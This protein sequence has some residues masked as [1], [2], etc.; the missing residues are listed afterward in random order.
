MLIVN[1]KTYN[2][3]VEEV[4][5]ALKPEIVNGKLSR[6]KVTSSGINV[7]CPVH[8]GGLE[9]HPSC[10]INDEGI[11]HCFTCGAKGHIDGFIANCLDITNS[12]AQEWLASKFDYDLLGDELELLPIEFTSK[13]QVKALDES[14]LNTF[15]SFHPYMVKRKLDRD[16]CEKFKVK[17][18]EKSE[19]IVFPVWDEKNN[20]VMFTRRCVNNKRFDIDK[21]VEKPVYL[22]NFIENEGIKDVVVCESQINALYSWSLGHPAIA[23]FG[24]GTSN[25]YNILNKSGI[26]HY[27]LALDGDN[28]GKKGIERFTK[29]IRKDVFVDVLAIPDG[30]DL[31]DLTKEEVNK[32]FLCI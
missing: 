16:I 11:W 32:L 18:D 25:Q 9:S 5:D 2:L 20:L 17:Y 10:Y 13:P 7:P 19:S 4:L 1:N 12:Q 14:I 15:Q 22:L 28:A 27:I 8:S 21:G 3:S 6:Y 29:N 30:K 24:T 31:N 23:L 26:R